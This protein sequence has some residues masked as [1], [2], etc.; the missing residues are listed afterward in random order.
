MTR[1][2]WGVA[3]FGM[4]IAVVLVVYA[5]ARGAPWWACL[6]IACG[7]LLLLTVP[8]GL[9]LWATIRHGDPHDVTYRYR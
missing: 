1:V 9:L 7:P 6:F 4:L 3:A 2:G 8:A 5:D